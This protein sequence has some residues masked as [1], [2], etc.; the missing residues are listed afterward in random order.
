MSGP[1]FS[2]PELIQA[3]SKCKNIY[4][5]FRDEYESAPA[6]IRDLVDTCKYLRD[7]L[8]DIKSTVGDV[9]SQE[10]SFG[11]KLD[12]CNAFISKYKSLKEDY[13]R[14]E[15]EATMTAM[16]RQKWEQVWQT[17][18]YAFDSD[19]ARD[20]KDALSLEIQKL[21]LFILVFAL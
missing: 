7:V 9:Y 11:R 17:T 16:L 3:I 21:V 10:H 12:E 13:L 15:G 19:R 2:I 20:L 6:R 14:S 4:D 1:G 18:T 8:E 5:T